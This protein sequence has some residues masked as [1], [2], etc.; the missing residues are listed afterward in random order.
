[1]Y[2]KK[3]D[4][5]T[6]FRL[7]RATW[8]LVHKKASFANILLTFKGI[9]PHYELFIWICFFHQHQ[10]ISWNTTE[11]R[12]K[13]IW[14][15]LRALVLWNRG[16]HQIN[17]EHMV[18][19]HVVWRRVHPSIHYIHLRWL[20]TETF[21]TRKLFSLNMTATW[22]PKGQSIREDHLIL[23]DMDRINWKKLFT[24]C[25]NSL[26]A[27]VLPQLCFQN[28]LLPLWDQKAPHTLQNCHHWWIKNWSLSAAIYTKL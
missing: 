17:K 16:K 5:G 6:T 28:F 21:H 4:K 26:Y 10:I 15:V 9:I 1:M 13:K 8:T 19:R 3:R 22:S 14:E 27:F 18:W 2:W 25:Q 12:F 23:H 7:K 24:T 20:H 11:L